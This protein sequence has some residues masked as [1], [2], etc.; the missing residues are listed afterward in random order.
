MSFINILQITIKV[1][2]DSQNVVCIHFSF[3]LYGK[4]ENYTINAVS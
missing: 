4:V 3:P 1:I 2:G